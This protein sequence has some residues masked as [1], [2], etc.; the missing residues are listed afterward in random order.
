MRSVHRAVANLKKH[1][2]QSSG[3]CKMQTIVAYWGGEG[4][5]W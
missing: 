3:K 4:E 1:K 2:I 5:S